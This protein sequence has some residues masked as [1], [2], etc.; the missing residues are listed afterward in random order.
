MEMQGKRFLTPFGMTTMVRACHFDRREKSF[1]TA[2]FKG[3]TT[4]EIV[5]IHRRGAGLAE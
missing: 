1:S 5:V 2:I 4:T 3:G